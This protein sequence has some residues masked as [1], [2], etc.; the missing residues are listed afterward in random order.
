KSTKNSC[1]KAGSDYTFH[2]SL[3]LCD[4][5]ENILTEII[6]R[7]DFSEKTAHIA[8]I[9][10]VCKSALMYAVFI[11]IIALVILRAVRANQRKGK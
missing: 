7:T 11:I 1:F 2:P 9:I 6:L 10:T 3:A 8:S 4:Y 5:A